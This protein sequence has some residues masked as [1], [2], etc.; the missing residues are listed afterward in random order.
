M[1]EK[2]PVPFKFLFKKVLSYKIFSSL[3]GFAI[4]H[5]VFVLPILTYATYSGI[6]FPVLITL[7]ISIWIIGFIFGWFINV[8][9]FLNSYR[10]IFLKS[11][12]F[13]I[14]KKHPLYIHRINLGLSQEQIDGLYVL[15]INQ[16]L[17]DGS[18]PG[19]R[20]IQ[21]E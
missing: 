4:F 5:V 6:P 9:L 16:S 2:Q 11:G 18:F 14:N 7:M 12:V 3:A 17:K 10:P 8:P 1:N 19:M 15:E 13:A 20:P 21:S